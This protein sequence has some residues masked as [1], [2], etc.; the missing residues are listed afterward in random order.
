MKSDVEEKIEMWCDAD[1][2]SRIEDIAKCPTL[3]ELMD[4]YLTTWFTERN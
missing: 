2:R 4:W 3:Q 1:R